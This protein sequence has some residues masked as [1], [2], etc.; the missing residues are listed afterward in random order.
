MFYKIDLLSAYRASIKQDSICSGGSMALLSHSRKLSAI[1]A[2]KPQRLVQTVS[3]LIVVSH[4]VTAVKYHSLKRTKLIYVY[5]LISLV[6]VIIRCNGKFRSVVSKR[7]EYHFIFE[8]LYFL[9]TLTFFN[10]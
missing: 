1:K 5:F 6:K 2:F 8:E 4:H 9:V 7:I 3:Q 10:Q